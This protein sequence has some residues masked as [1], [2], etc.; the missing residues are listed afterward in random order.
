MAKLIGRDVLKTHRNRKRSDNRPS[1][2]AAIRNTVKAPITMLVLCIKNRG[3]YKVQEET[4][5]TNCKIDYA[6][7]S[8]ERVSCA[9]I[10][11][12]HLT[13]GDSL[14]SW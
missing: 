12:K 7:T 6:T 14:L 4:Q 13:M 3:V 9:S 8:M 2:G 1:D 10:S 11:M 5:V